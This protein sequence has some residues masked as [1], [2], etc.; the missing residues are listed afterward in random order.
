MTKDLLKEVGNELYEGTKETLFEAL[1][2]C[3]LEE[4]LEFVKNIKELVKKTKSIPDTIFWS[5]FYLFLQK[6]NFNYDIL[7]KLAARLEESGNKKENA[8]RIIYAINRI[9]DSRKAKFISWLT[10]SVI[11]REIEFD[12]YFRLIKKVDNLVYEDL[13]YLSEQVENQKIDSEDTHIDEF[14][15]NGLIYRITGGFA[16]SVQAYDLIKYGIRRGNTVRYPEK[17]QERQIMETLVD[18]QKENL[19]IHM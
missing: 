14:L 9:D 19:L 12:N 8:N 13:M 16:Y 17:M 11:H 3:L 1:A 6:G 5:N 15:A 4:P 10:L 7:R 18:V 2:N